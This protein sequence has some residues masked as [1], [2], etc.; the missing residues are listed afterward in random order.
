MRETKNMQ[1]NEL[2]FDDDE[3][4][5]RELFQA[6]WKDILKKYSKGVPLLFVSKMK[7][8]KIQGG[9]LVFFKSSKKIPKKSGGT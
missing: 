9:N 7:E 4:D 2:Y 8:T 3:I 6:L 1:E 5:L